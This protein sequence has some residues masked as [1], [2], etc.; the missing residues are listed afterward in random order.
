[1]RPG[2]GGGRKNNKLY[3]AHFGCGENGPALQMRRRAL[4]LGLRGPRKQSV[5]GSGGS[6]IKKGKFLFFLSSGRGKTRFQFKKNRC[7]CKKGTNNHNVACLLFVPFV[8]RSG[9]P[10]SCWRCLVFKHRQHDTGRLGTI[11]LP[12]ASS[13][14]ATRTLRLK[15]SSV[16]ILTT[17][18]FCWPT[19]VCL[20]S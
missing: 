14:A 12:G 10:V 15:K 7:S 20:C 13:H 11:L 19:A 3:W 9:Q 8:S 17:H 6:V 18:D 5:G 2:R 16:C 4:L 1:M